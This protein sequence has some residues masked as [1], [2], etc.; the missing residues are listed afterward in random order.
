MNE[1]GWSFLGQRTLGRSRLGRAETPGKDAPNGRKSC[2]DVP[3]GLLS[4]RCEQITASSAP[5]HRNMGK[6]PIK[7]IQ[8]C[9]QWQASG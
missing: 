2:L 8:V 3:L 9:V 5:Q 4:P 7:S 6:Q 1:L